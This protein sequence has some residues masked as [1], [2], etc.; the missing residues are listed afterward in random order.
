[1]E[2]KFKENCDV[3]EISFISEITFT[4]FCANISILSAS[5][6]C[7]KYNFYIN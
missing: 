1:M 5:V 6:Q 2:R 3:S 7:L 4:H